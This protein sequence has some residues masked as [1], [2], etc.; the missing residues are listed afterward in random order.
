MFCRSMPAA[1][2]RALLH[3]LLGLLPE[4]SSPVVISVKPDQPRPTPI[5]PNGNR[6]KAT[7][8]SYDP[9]TVFILELATV[10][11][12][13]DAESV[14][15]MAQPVADALQYVVRDSANV[16]PLTLS[17]AV[18][19]LLFLLNASQEHSFV[20]APVILHTISNYEQATIEA[21]EEQ[22]AHGL[23]ICVGK[24]SPLRN[25]IT[26]T[27]DFWLLVRSLHNRPAVAGRI[28]D[29]LSNVIEGKPATITA[30]NYEASIS[31]LNNFAAAGSIGA[32]VEQ[33]RDRRSAEISR[34]KKSSR[35]ATSPRK[36]SKE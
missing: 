33:Q 24:P 20:R 9:S 13:R 14:E 19:Y 11:A 3:A 6:S 8:S 10:L 1:S 28:F 35:R 26:N 16:H 7:H 23:E 31:A 30:D 27:P 34:D 25:E 18:F 21:T 2:R 32:A 36:P 15:L 12:T 29:I 4:Q 5:R 17:R 22:I